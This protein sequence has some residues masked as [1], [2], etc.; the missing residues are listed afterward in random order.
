M[1]LFPHDVQ[2]CFFPRVYNLQY[3]PFPSINI[4]TN[5]TSVWFKGLKSNDLPFGFH[6]LESLPQLHGRDRLSRKSIRKPF[7]KQSVLRERELFRNN[8]IMHIFSLD[9][10]INASLT[11]LAT[12]GPDRGLI[13][14]FYR[15]VECKRLVLNETLFNEVLVAILDLLRHVLR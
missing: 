6:I 9:K 10:T 5:C 8:C 11:F 3:S 2:G 12:I 13:A 4:S 1:L 15:L 14:N 7:R